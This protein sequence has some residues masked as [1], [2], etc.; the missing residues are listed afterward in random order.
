M[1]FRPFVP[2]WLAREVYS[3][4]RMNCL[5]LREVVLVSTVREIPA[6]PLSTS[7]GSSEDGRRQQP[8]ERSLLLPPQGPGLISSCGETR[9]RF[10][11]YDFTETGG[12]KMLP[13]PCAFGS[14]HSPV[15]VLID[16]RVRIVT[17]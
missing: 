2:T 16:R 8:L 11:S 13:A 4:R 5:V 15:D 7:K 9:R 12:R 6:L 10:T 3:I 17:T 1:V 14:N